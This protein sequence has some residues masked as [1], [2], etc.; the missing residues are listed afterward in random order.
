M[1]QRL[2]QRTLPS[3]QFPPS[4]RLSSCSCARLAFSFRT[5][6]PRAI[7]EPF[8]SQLWVTRPRSSPSP[9]KMER[10]ATRAR[11][12]TPTARLSETAHS[13]SSSVPGSSRFVRSFVL[14]SCWPVEGGG[15]YCRSGGA[16]LLQT[17]VDDIDCSSQR[18]RLL[19]RVCF[20]FCFACV[21]G[22]APGRC[23]LRLVLR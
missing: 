16:G 4:F 19:T 23:G 9:A 5:L 21:V 7:G 8:A 13:A 1:S 14:L 10:R 22:V 6:T 3:T 18:V 20:F 11:S 17:A 15:E 2:Q 12:R